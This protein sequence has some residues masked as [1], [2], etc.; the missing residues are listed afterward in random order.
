M[1]F[2]S[3]FS[4]DSDRPV[5]VAGRVKQLIDKGETVE[6]GKLMYSQVGTPM[7][8]MT[9]KAPKSMAMVA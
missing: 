8:A 3:R 4:C 9:K 2:H 1:D 5:N 6:A 7:V